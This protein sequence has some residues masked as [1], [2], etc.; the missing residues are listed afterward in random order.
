[1]ES[2]NL[3]GSPRRL[4]VSVLTGF[5]GGGKSTVLDCLIQQP[6]PSPTL[7]L[8]NEFGQIGLDHD[9][10]THSNLRQVPAT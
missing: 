9:L 1:M 2:W 4:P 5:P 3:R 6:A 8:A 10:V 7:V